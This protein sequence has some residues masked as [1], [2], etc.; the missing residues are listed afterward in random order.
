MTATN[1]FHVGLLVHDLPAAVRR[2][3]DLLG[4]RF[5]E[6]QTFTVVVDEPGG[7]T[8]R[9]LRAVY[10]VDGPPFL[11]LIEAQ[12]D[13]IWAEAHGEGLHHIGVW[14]DDLAAREAA[15]RRAGVPPAA[16]IHL[17]GRLVAI[18]MAAAEAH[19]ARVELVARHDL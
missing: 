2:F 17:D 5:A 13:G 8:T 10:S 16:T 11:E 9:E 6:P 4:L 7:S 19:G 15:L 1:L 14:E 3:S 18:Y 12:D